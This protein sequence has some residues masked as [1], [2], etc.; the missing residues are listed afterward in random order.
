MVV[1]MQCQRTKF[2]MHDRNDDSTSAMHKLIAWALRNC[3]SFSWQ[4]RTE[5][6]HLPKLKG[7][8]L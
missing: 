6:L 3:Y 1:K 5:Y 4:C 2:A 8:N 7:K